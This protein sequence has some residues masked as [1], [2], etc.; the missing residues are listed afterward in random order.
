M[1]KLFTI[2]C[3]ITLAFSVSA[4]SWTDR[5]TDDSYLPKTGDWSIG[6]DATSTLDYFGN[7]FNSSASAPTATYVSEDRFDQT[8]Y[9]KLMTSDTEAWRVRLGIK[10]FK[11]TTRENVPDA[12]SSSGD[13]TVTDKETDG[14][15]DIKLWLGKE[16]RR[17]S[18]R[19]QGVYGAE[20]G[21]GLDSRTEKKEYGNS[22]ENG[23][24]G[25]VKTK[26][27]MNLGVNLRAFIGFEYFMMPK[28]SIGGEYGWGFEFQSKGGGST[29]ELDSDGKETTT[30]NAN[31]SEMGFKNDDAGG[32]LVL[33][34][35]F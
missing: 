22:P 13:A 2:M 24:V 9:G 16:Y 32:S 33:R 19:L 5:W 18:S 12:G 31:D 35:Y 15:T 25:V 4:Q 30:D 3:A 11:E 34:M 28:M 6:F 10:M 23:G 7:L 27:G 1:K 14:S 20:A 26:H 21:I 29:T 17:G 8:I